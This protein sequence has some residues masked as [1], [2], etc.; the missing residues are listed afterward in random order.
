MN[1]RSQ[2]TAK[3]LGHQGRAGAR[4]PEGLG[5]QSEKQGTFPRS[6]DTAEG[7]DFRDSPLT[8]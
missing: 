3:Q 1:H 2:P 5:T 4:R 7:L 6:G 8:A